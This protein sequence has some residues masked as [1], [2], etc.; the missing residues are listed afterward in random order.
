MMDT[1]RMNRLK[2][3]GSMPGA[4]CYTACSGSLMFACVEGMTTN[5][6]C[7]VITRRKPGPS[8]RMLLIK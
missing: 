6:P 1:E 3:P 4:K 8:A 2:G 7:A 5:D